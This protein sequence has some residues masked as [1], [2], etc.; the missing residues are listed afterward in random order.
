MTANYKFL[1]WEREEGE[2][3]YDKDEQKNTERI[4]PSPV[5]SQGRH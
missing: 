3:G 2:A 1:R 5:F 4:E